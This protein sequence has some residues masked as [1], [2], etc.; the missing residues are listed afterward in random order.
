MAAQQASSKHERC[1]PSTRTAV[2]HHQQTCAAARYQLGEAQC[3]AIQ[4]EGSRASAGV[5]NLQ[6]FHQ[7][8]IEPSRK[9][10]VDLEV[11]RSL[12]AVSEICLRKARRHHE[13][14]GNL[15]SVHWVAH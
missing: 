14:Y 10:F 15:Q 9:V 13:L 1:D 8:D 4:R 12:V 3:L 5:L 6:H 2:A 7:S 11:N